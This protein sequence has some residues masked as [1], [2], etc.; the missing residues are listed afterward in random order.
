MHDVGIIFTGE[1]KTRAA[2]IRG[3][4]VDLIKWAIDH[5]STKISVTQIANREIVGLRCC[6]L[7]QI[8][9]YTSNPEPIAL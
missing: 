8:E 3:Q 4:L 9:I 1:N 6:E 2:H 7:R 5:L